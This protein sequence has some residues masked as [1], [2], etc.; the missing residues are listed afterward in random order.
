MSVNISITLLRLIQ[1]Q[2]TH[3]DSQYL[4]G[5]IKMR[6]NIILDDEII[7]E[8]KKLT[9]LKTKKD[10]VDFALRELIKKLKKKNRLS[11]RRRG[12]WEGNLKEMRRKRI[13]T[14]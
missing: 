13:D 4:K 7:K 11:L 1:L 8:A 5:G 14:H 2:Y 10:I 9:S 3:Y 6:T 12:L